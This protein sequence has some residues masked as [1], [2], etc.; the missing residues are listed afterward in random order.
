MMS[1]S[2]SVVVLGMHRSG[3]SALTGILEQAGL[4]LGSV[5]EFA[6]DNLRGNREST[7]VMALHN[8]ILQRN[9][10]SWDQPP[11][12]PNWSPVHF[13]FRDTII[14]TYKD[15]LLWGFKDP[16]TLLMLGP[17]LKV[18]PEAV[19]IGIYRHPFAVAQSLFE[20][21]AMP[22]EKSLALWTHYNR[23][24]LWHSRNNDSMPLVEFSNNDT[25]F[26]NQVRSVINKLGLSEVGLEF[27]DSSL[28]QSNFPDLNFIEQ[29]A[30]AL[31]VYTQLQFATGLSIGPV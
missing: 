21:N 9:G 5:S 12:N 4:Y 7:A 22:Y 30:S 1:N 2:T 6:P 20:R 19:L 17:W 26:S 11:N 24:M 13:A 28:K 29:S 25:S 27:F 15:K 18:L 8:D 23:I 14:E 3:T 10:G 16:R 31:S